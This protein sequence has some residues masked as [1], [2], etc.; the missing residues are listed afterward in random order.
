MR[1]SECLVRRSSESPITIQV[2][3]GNE[4]F[5]VS[6]S[7]PDMILCE[8]VPKYLRTTAWAGPLNMSPCAVG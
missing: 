1:F 6:L 2:I 3:D 7:D 5:E 4:L 8:Y